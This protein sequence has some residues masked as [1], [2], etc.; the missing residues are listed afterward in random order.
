MAWQRF[1]GTAVVVWRARTKICGIQV[2][3][4]HGLS[5]VKVHAI[6]WWHGVL[7]LGVVYCIC[8]WHHMT[9]KCICGGLLSKSSC[10]GLRTKRGVAFDKM[11]Q[12]NVLAVSITSRTNHI[13]TKCK[14]CQAKCPGSWNNNVS[15]NALSRLCADCIWSLFDRLQIYGSP[16]DPRQWTRLDYGWWLQDNM[17]PDNAK[18]EIQSVIFDWNR[19]TVKWCWCWCWWCW[20]CWRWWWLCW[21]LLPTRLPSC[22][23]SVGF[24]QVARESLPFICRPCMTYG[25][26]LTHVTYDTETFDILE[27]CT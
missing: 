1:S 17:K 23:Q 5:D 2:V 6:I 11:Q 16:D 9:L 20:W 3:Q 27:T 8:A 14:T 4:M 10:P 24:L 22:H 18:G 19:V 25:Q 7:Y 21:L 15:S 13:S 12:C 26:T